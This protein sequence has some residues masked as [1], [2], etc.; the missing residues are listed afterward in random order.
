MSLLLG[1][2]MS[3]FK[4]ESKIRM[5]NNYHILFFLGLSY[6][7]FH[8]KQYKFFEYF[9]NGLTLSVCIL[10]LWLNMVL[11]SGVCNYF[12]VANLLFG[13]YVKVLNLCKG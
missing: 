10:L 9:Y 7:S 3:Q 8:T 6:S 12:L 13:V 1:P 5:E 2:Q 4:R 11:L